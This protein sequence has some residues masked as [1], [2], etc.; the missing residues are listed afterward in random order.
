ME[1]CKTKFGADYPDT[2]MSM[3]NL[4]FTWKDQG[5]HLDALVL[6]EDCAQARQRVLGVEYPHTL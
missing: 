5:R 6:L 4:A 3:G 2:L 1:T